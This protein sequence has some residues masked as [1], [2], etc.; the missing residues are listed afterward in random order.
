MYTYGPHTTRLS[1]SATYSHLKLIS[2][3]S[4][5]HANLNRSR[6]AQA[7]KVSFKQVFETT[8]L[9]RAFLLYLPEKCLPDSHKKLPEVHKA[10]DFIMNLMSREKRALT[11]KTIR[12]MK[13][14][15]RIRIFHYIATNSGSIIMVPTTGKNALVSQYGDK[16]RYHLQWQRQ[17]NGIRRYSTLP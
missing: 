4:P 2:S 7:L 8:L 3:S 17:Q 16:H 5:T 14:D 6:C 15:F 9:A 11:I 1:F 12:T 10:S 13:L